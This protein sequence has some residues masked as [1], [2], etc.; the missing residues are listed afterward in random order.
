MLQTTM[1]GDDWTSDQDKRRAAKLATARKKAGI[2]CAK[3][4]NAAAKA[5]S[6]YLMA[7]NECRDGSGSEQR[8]IS[9]G[10]NMLIR[11][12]CEYSGYL[13]SRYCRG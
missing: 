11:D 6:D 13:E 10:R 2:D 5:L 8:G 4:L 9:D 7:C 3:K 1:T 12:I